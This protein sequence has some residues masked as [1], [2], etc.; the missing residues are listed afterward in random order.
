[1]KNPIILALT[2]ILLS[3]CSYKV[4]KEKEAPLKFEGASLGFSQ[5][6][7]LALGPKCARCHDW[8]SSYTSTKAV[9][10]EISARVQSTTAGFQMPPASA[11]Q[12]TANEKA[13]IVAWVS[14]GAPEV[15]GEITQPITPPPVEPPPS[16]PAPPERLHFALVKAKVFDAKCMSCHGTEFDTFEHTKPWIK[17]I[18]FRIQD[19]GGA[20]QMPPPN[21]PQLTE[22]EKNMVLE[23]IRAGAPNEE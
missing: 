11:P 12:L 4:D 14:A 3:S 10:L 8:A 7:A 1:V 9:A 21:R 16:E 20:S 6:Q 5:V 23:W 22:E 15:P 13:A 19:I 17:E 18:E 2:G